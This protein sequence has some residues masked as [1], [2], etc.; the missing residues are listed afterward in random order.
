MSNTINKEKYIYDFGI[1]SIEILNMN[2]N[3][4]SCFVSKDIKIGTLDNDE[5]IQLSVDCDEKD[6]SIEFYIIDSSKC[7]AILPTEFK[8]IK[9]EKIFHSLRPRFSID[10]SENI[11]I[12]KDGAIVDLTLN[13]A[14]ANSSNCYTVSYLPANAYNI[15]TTS[16]SIQVKAILRAANSNSESPIVK[17]IAIKK[18]GRSSAWKNQMNIK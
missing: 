18:F 14:I 1:D 5:Y 10:E 15:R 4:N 7:K 11:I 3:K 9:D 6:G 17:N 2:T 13:Q 8:Y 12:K 16:D